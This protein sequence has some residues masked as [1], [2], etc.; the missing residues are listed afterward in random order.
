MH[1]KEVST[2]ETDWTSRI[3]SIIAIVI[4]LTGLAI[5]VVKLL[6]R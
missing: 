2:V 1:R 3:I 6:N 4:G 5:N